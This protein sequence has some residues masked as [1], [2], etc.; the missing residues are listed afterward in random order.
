[1]VV[2]LLRMVPVVVVHRVICQGSSTIGPETRKI[3]EPD[4]KAMSIK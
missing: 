4:R 1:M 2:I 3:F